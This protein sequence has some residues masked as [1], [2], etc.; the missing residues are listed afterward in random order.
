MSVLSRVV[1]LC[2]LLAWIIVPTINLEAEE[3]KININTAPLESLINIVHIGE[4]RGIEL[5]SLRP[6]TSLDD[7]SKINGISELRV[8][9]IKNQGI[10]FV[11]IIP[12]EKFSVEKIIQEY[13]KNIIFNELLPSPEGPDVENEWIE[14]FNKNNFEVDLSNW[15]ITDIKGTTKI[16]TF[17][18]GQ[19]IKANKYLLLSRRETKITLNNSGDGLQLLNPLKEIIDSVNYENAENK[20][21]FSLIKNSWIWNTELTPREKNIYNEVK[22]IVLEDE[23]KLPAENNKEIKIITT[24]DKNPYNYVFLATFISIISAG[25]IL[26]IKKN[27][28]IK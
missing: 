12:Q 23:D 5:I 22:A 9:D 3:E 21:S 6:F 28:R 20:K 7:L 26:L 19:I 25:V 15:Q 18:E 24:E 16:F 4:S 27:V 2:F 14:I 1:T 13:P 17:T 8:K 10:A 11:E